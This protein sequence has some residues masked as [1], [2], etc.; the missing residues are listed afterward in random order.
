MQAFRLGD[1]DAAAAVWE[2]HLRHTGETVADVLRA[3]Q[4]TLKR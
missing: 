2:T 1:P 3:K 4:T